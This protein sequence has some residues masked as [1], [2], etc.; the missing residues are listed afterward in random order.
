MLGHPT[1]DKA[2]SLP[3]NIVALYTLSGIWLKLGD[4]SEIQKLAPK[5]Y[6]ETQL[7]NRVC[8][9][10]TLKAQERQRRIAP[11]EFLESANLALETGAL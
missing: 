1:S 3:E 4:D 10:A 11:P 2:V 8:R 6:S 5:G 7:Y 9:F